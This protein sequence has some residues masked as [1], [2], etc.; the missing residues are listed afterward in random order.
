MTDPLAPLDALHRIPE[1]RQIRQHLDEDVGE[2]A[3]RTQKDDEIQPDRVRSTPNEVH[4][5]DELQQD[6]PGK[7]ER[8]EATHQFT[9]ERATALRSVPLCTAR[10]PRET[11]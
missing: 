2:R 1:E 7:Q 11:P 5:G 8:K 4:D 9:L 6:A 3:E 10:S